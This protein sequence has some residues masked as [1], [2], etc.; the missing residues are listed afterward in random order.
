MAEGRS[1]DGA[2][3]RAGETTMISPVHTAELA[4]QAICHRN[5][6]IGSGEGIFISSRL[7]RVHPRLFAND[8]VFTGR[9]PR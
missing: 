5:V 7:L 3:H 8:I 9:M 4:D 1:L 2:G 6:D